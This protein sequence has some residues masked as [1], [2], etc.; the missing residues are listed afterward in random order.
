[1][2]GLAGLAVGIELL[3][4]VAN[5]AFEVALGKVGEG[6]KAAG[7]FVSALVGLV[8]LLGAPDAVALGGLG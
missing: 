5:A 2:L 3:A 7:L 4:Q 8:P 1:M 6:I